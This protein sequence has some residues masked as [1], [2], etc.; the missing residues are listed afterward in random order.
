MNVNISPLN[1]FEK[2]VFQS[3]ERNT[4]SIHLRYKY[5]DAYLKKYVYFNT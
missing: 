2:S 4:F 5:Y 1:S 3:M